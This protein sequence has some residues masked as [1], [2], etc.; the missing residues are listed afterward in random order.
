MDGRA[1]GAIDRVDVRPFPVSITSS[2]SGTTSPKPIVRKVMYW[3]YREVP[4]SQPS[5]QQYSPAMTAVKP[6]SRSNANQNGA[7]TWPSSP[8]LPLK[9]ERGHTKVAPVLQS[10]GPRSCTSCALHSA[11]FAVGCFFLAGRESRYPPPPPTHTQ[12]QSCSHAV[13]GILFLRYFFRTR[14]A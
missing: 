5:I 14:T 8:E 11:H 6:N 4:K 1:G 9:A 2:F 7:S 10:D 13:S 12:A 3:K